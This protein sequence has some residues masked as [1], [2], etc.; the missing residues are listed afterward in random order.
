[1]WPR[2][3]SAR[4]ER[5]W[6]GGG[7]LSAGGTW[8]LGSPPSRSLECHLREARPHPGQRR[9]L[10][11]L[12]VHCIYGS[13]LSLLL[14]L[15]IPMFSCFG[16]IISGFPRHASCSVQFICWIHVVMAEGRQLTCSDSTRGCLSKVDALA[17][18]YFKCFVFFVVSIFVH[19]VEMCHSLYIFRDL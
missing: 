18:R 2:G 6:R 10:E 14:K 4:G 15:N 12:C 8:S 16:L 7:A 3:R 5:D 17:E 1:M 11:G 9:A 13:C 19:P